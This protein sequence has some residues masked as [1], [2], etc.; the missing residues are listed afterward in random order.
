MNTSNPLFEL[1]K[2]C[3]CCGIT[4]L[5]TDECPDCGYDEDLNTVEEYSYIMLLEDQTEE[6]R[7][8]FERNLSESELQEI[9]NHFN[10]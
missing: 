3:K 5:Y 2:K 9:E 6:M 1:E 10:N 8:I 4:Y 7:A